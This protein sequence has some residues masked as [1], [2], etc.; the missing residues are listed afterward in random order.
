M[1]HEVKLLNAEDG[2]AVAACHRIFA[3]LRPHLDA[4]EFAKRVDIQ[5]KE[6]YSIVYIEVDDE[7]LAAAGFR[8]AHFLA[9]GKVLYIDDLITLPGR[10]R[11]GLGG[12][13]MDWLIE[14]GRQQDCDEVHLDTGFLRHAAHRL[15]LNKGLELSC[16][17]LSRKLK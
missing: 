5:A 15:Y 10:T 12:A 13:L 17:H 8:V 9:W 14:H 6:N 3:L 7:I 2:R 16:H 11:Q 1:T 4:A